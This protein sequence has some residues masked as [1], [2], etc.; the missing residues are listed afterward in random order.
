MMD[1]FTEEMKTWLFDLA[2]GNLQE[3]DILKGFLKH[4]VLYGCELGNVQDDIAF[5]TPYGYEGVE[6]AMKD[7]KE[8]LYKKAGGI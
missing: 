6:K 5:H 3:D 2:H 1:R 8:V 7:L 4:Y